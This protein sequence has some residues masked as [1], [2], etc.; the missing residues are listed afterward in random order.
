MCNLY[1]QVDVI[2]YY[3]VLSMIMTCHDGTQ[4]EIEGE[5]CDNRYV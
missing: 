5:L 3:T 1:E 2:G 4:T